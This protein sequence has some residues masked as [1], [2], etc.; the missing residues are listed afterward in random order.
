MHFLLFGKTVYTLHDESYSGLL[1][2]CSSELCN[3]SIRTV[4]VEY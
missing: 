2:G 1:A 3:L 4:F